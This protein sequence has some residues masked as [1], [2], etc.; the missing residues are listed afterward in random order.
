MKYQIL[1]FDN[2]YPQVVA[3]NMTRAVQQLLDVGWHPLGQPQ[4]VTRDSKTIIMQA[5]VFDD[6]KPSRP[7]HLA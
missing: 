6:A 4:L 5:L 1:V 3:E 2:C 7:L